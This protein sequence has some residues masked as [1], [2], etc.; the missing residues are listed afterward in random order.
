MTRATAPETPH[1]VPG[2]PDCARHH[3]DWMAAVAR[4]DQSAA[5]DARVL[6][7]RHLTAAHPQ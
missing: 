2:C 3:R 1:P 7:R 6:L 5:T 4:A